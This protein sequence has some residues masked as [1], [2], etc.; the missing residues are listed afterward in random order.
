MPNKKAPKKPGIG[1]FK[2][3]NTTIEGDSTPIVDNDPGF[4]PRDDAL[5][6]DNT[7]KKNFTNI[8]QCII[9]L[10]D[11]PSDALME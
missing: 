3:D 9:D 7:K 2:S 8:T 4:D 1:M 10:C 11:F 5:L 6:N